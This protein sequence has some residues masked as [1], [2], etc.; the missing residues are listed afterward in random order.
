MKT[1]I[2]SMIALCVSA[3]ATTVMAETIALWHFDEGTP[4]NTATTLSSEYNP[5]IME[6][7]AG[8]NAEGPVPYFSD[9]IGIPYLTE[10]SSGTV[11]STN[12]CSLKFT[13]TGLPADP[14]SHKGGIIPIPYNEIMVMSNLTAEAFVKIDRLVNFPL[15]IGKA[16]S[17]GNTT[18]NI[19][20][21]AT[22]NPRLRIDSNPTGD[23]SNGWNQSATSS[24]D[25]NDGKWHHVAFTYTHSTKVARLYVDYTQTASMT[26]WSNLVYETLEMRIGQGC[27]GRA[28]DG[29]IDEVRLS[30]EVLQPADFMVFAPQGDT[31]GYWDFD[32]PVETA[33]SILTN[34]VFANPY[35]N[36]MHGTAAVN[37]SSGVKPQ[38]TNFLPS[39]TLIMVKDGAT[40]ETVNSNTT[41][42]FFRNSD[43]NA[44]P[45]SQ[46]GSIVNIT[47][48]FIPDFPTNFTVEAFV[49][50]DRA[51]KWP[52]IIGKRR[53]GGG[54]YS[55]SM[56]VEPTGN[57]RCRFDTTDPVTLTN[58]VNNQIIHAGGS[59][60]DDNWHHVAVSYYY[61]TKS[62]KIYVDHELKNTMTT[63]YP[64]YLDDDIIQIGAGDRAFDGWIDEV[65]ITKRV[66][67]PSEFLYLEEP[68]NPPGT[69]ILIQ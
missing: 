8:S 14:G 42:L 21:N 12:K 18:W 20:M 39:S 3:F 62:A 43:T 26:T 5:T 55:W 47:A 54:T 23:T 53:S 58:H 56:G 36:V 30:D 61:P 52:Q 41:S 6:G 33:A 46:N 24:V 34:Q 32:G 29:W 65:R 44:I 4:T 60:Y 66:L 15:I 59:I 69:I 9:D 25:I 50:A 31:Y 51:A 38:F 11:T 10:G 57:L 67:D 17:A 27:G 48:P 37:G 19:D 35:V 16:R 63:T 49:K 7:T 2:K 1:N 28:F 68:P 40:G 45:Y 64:M 13:N 22:G